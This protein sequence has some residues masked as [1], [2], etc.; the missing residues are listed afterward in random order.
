MNTQPQ[1][2]R[3]AWG[4]GRATLLLLFTLFLPA[5]AETS[6]ADTPRP[7]TIVITG[8]S[9]VAP[10]MAEIAGR[11]EA[12]HPH[13]RI[14][15]QTGGSSRGI[16]DAQRGIADIGMSSRD[17]TAGEAQTLHAHP[18]ASDGIC[19]ITHRD[20]PVASLTRDELVDIYTARQSTWPDSGEDIVVINKADGRATLDVFLNYTGLDNRDI[21]AD[22]I[23][24]DNEQGIKTVAANPAAIGYVSIGAA[25]VNQSLNIP[26]RL[27][28][29]DAN[30][31][32]LDAVRAGGW[33]LTRPLILVTADEPTGV[34]ADLITFARSPAVDD[35]KESLH[36]VPLD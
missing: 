24:G 27:I 36:V 10:L 18:I 34:I 17:L 14:D 30:I 8:S 26:I 9:T 2:S 3:V 16:V 6:T 32:S 22:V 13:I 19:I 28:P 23:I 7:Q 25:V 5:C 20:N 15:V 35:L 11:Y 33:P 12:D 31:P 1:P 21:H 4:C 29:I